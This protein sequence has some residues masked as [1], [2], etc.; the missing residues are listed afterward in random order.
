MAEE[1]E[2]LSLFDD[3]GVGF[4][5]SPRNKGSGGG[6]GNGMSEEKEEEEET[7]ISTTEGTLIPSPSLPEEGIGSKRRWNLSRFFFENVFFY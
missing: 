6:G 1:E 5:S 2:L 7:L 3:D 4:P